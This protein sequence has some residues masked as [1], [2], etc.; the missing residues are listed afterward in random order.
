MARSP[1]SWRTGRTVVQRPLRPSQSHPCDRP[2]PARLTQRARRS[3]ELPS[4]CTATNVRSQAFRVC[5]LHIPAL[6]HRRVCLIRSACSSAISLR[7]QRSAS[8][9]VTPSFRRMHTPHVA[10]LTVSCTASSAFSLSQPIRPSFT[11]G[12]LSALPRLKLLGFSSSF[13]S[14]IQCAP[15]GIVKRSVGVALA[16]WPLLFK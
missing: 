5:A 3:L 11:L 13:S 8:R 4:S 9:L 15:A 2:P 7:S 10:A 12:C 6:C 16:S 1:H 14:T